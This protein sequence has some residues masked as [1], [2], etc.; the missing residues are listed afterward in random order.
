[1]LWLYTTGALGQEPGQTI[2]RSKLR[3]SLRNVPGS[4]QSRGAQ[5]RVLFSENPSMSWKRIF[6]R[7]EAPKPTGT[8]VG[9]VYKGTNKIGDLALGEVIGTGKSLTD[10]LEL[11]DQEIPKWRGRYVAKEAYFI[12]EKGGEYELD[13]LELVRPGKEPTAAVGKG[14]KPKWRAVVRDA[15]EPGD[16]GIFDRINFYYDFGFSTSK[17]KILPAHP[18]V[19][20]PHSVSPSLLFSETDPV[21]Q[22]KVVLSGIV[23]DGKISDPENDSMSARD[24]EASVL[25]VQVTEAEA[26]QPFFARALESLS[27]LSAVQ[28]LEKQVLDALAPLAGSEEWEAL[29]KSIIRTAA[30]VTDRYARKEQTKLLLGILESAFTETSLK[31]VVKRLHAELPDQDWDKTAL[32]NHLLPDLNKEIEGAAGQ[33]QE[34]QT[35]RDSLG[36]LERFPIP[37]DATI[38]ASTRDS[39]VAVLTPRVEQLIAASEAGKAILEIEGVASPPKDPWAP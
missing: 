31:S 29:R 15:P 6:G 35:L 13:R 21:E 20:F 23:K 26:V 5:Q 39:I 33:R 17:P 12:R 24:W 37:T 25:P 4:L 2:C 27:D 30:K 8:V 16:V 28:D 11:A 10:V 32:A 22:L 19:K 36:K 9:Q 18:G 38:A 1:M 34:L 14:F 7:S 3:L